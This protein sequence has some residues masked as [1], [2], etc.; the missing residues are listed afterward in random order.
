MKF[1]LSGIFWF[2]AALLALEFGTEIMWAMCLI[3][4]NIWIAL[5]YAVDALK[6]KSTEDKEI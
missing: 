5:G 6:S 3:I 2:I 1:I 4:A